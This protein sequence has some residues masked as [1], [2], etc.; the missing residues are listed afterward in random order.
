VAD[1]QASRYLNDEPGQENQEL[2]DEVS[3]LR[4]AS[5]RPEDPE[6]AERWERERAAWAAEYADSR[7]IHQARIDIAKETVARAHS[8]AEFVR[9]A[10]AS[11]VTLYSGVL[12]I[13][14]ALDRGREGL[15]PARGIL[16]AIFLSGAIIGATAYVALIQK[17]RP[18]HLPRPHSSL[19]ELQE[20][21]L[22]SLVD[23]LADITLRRAYALHAAVIS[24][25]MGTAFLPAPFLTGLDDSQW[26]SAGIVAA[27]IT[28]ALPYFTTRAVLNIDSPRLKVSVG[29]AVVSFALS[30]LIVRSGL[31]E[32]ELVSRTVWLFGAALIAGLLI[33]GLRLQ[34][35]GRNAFLVASLVIAFLALQ[36][37]YDLTSDITLAGDCRDVDMSNAIFTGE[38]GSAGA[39]V[40]DLPDRDTPVR[41]SL[42]ASCKVGFDAYCVGQSRLNPQTNVPDGRWFRLPGS[43]RLVSAAEISGRPPQTFEAVDCEGGKKTPSP[44][45]FIAP[46]GP[47]LTNRTTIRVAN[48]DGLAIGFLIGRTSENGMDWNRIGFDPDPSDGST[49]TWA[50]DGTSSGPVTISAVVCL[51]LSA[52]SEVVKTKV[53]TIGSRKVAQLP[54]PADPTPRAREAAC[55]IAS[56]PDVSSKSTTAQP[57]GCSPAYPDICLRLEVG[58]YDCA[59]GSGNGPNYVTGRTRVLPPDPFDLDVDGDGRACE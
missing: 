19:P 18:F 1:Q 14:S 24:L 8:A 54:Q 10:A 44:V 45:S 43:R 23:W 49:V 3:R 6:T 30:Y 25:A 51:S 29:F 38:T 26:V 40:H 53:F 16:P 35:F 7:A 2:V 58:D 36:T 39:E 13:T 27:V 34:G 15:F 37:T 17:P 20:R 48:D 12:G 21:R 31:T 32:G 55:N 47:N 9:N 4:Q 28:L 33:W 59:G 57:G 11:I 42:P 22:S 46:K 41:N 56:E 5:A 50:A 52:P